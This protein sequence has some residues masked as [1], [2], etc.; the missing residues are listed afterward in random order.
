MRFSESPVIKEGVVIMEAEHILG[1]R[2]TSIE[3]PDLPTFCE[4]V[5]HKALASKVKGHI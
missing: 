2:P 4:K 3:H 5:R 1:K